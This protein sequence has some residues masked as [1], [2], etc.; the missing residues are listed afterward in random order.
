[1]FA[2]GIRHALSVLIALEKL[3]QDQVSD[4]RGTY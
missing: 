3:E 2:V 4:K 1:M